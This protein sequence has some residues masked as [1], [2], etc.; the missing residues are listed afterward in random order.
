LVMMVLFIALALAYLGGRLAR[1]SCAL[2]ASEAKF[3][4]LFES[5]GDAIFLADPDTG[6]ILDAN[7]AAAKLIGRERSQI[8]GMHQSQLHPADQVEDYRQKFERHIREGRAADFE[9]EALRA[10][11]STVPV[12]IGASLVEVA[13]RTV[14]QGRFV[15][16]TERKRAEEALRQSE[17]RFRSL[18]ESTSDWIWEVDENGVYTYV[19]PRVR[20]ILGYEPEEVIGKTPFD[21]MPPEEAARVGDAFGELAASREPLVALENTNLHKD[22]HL[23]VLET[24]GVPVFDADGTFRGY[25]GVDRDIT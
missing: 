2:R 14:I 16:L 23:V 22:G 21:L 25:R 8:I 18:V 19:S 9:A 3:R 20:D 12:F 1:E 24:S 7:S 4:A 6:E 17:D 15:D 13:G 11:G 5:A 10:D